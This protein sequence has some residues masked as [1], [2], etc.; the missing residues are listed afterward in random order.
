MTRLTAFGVGFL[1]AAG[2]VWDSRRI[3]HCD[4]VFTVM[5]GLQENREYNSLLNTDALTDVFSDKRTRS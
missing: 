3:R 5:V 4:G 1:A 2:A